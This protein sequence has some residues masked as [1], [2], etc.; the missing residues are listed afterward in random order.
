MVS[1]G[2]PALPPDVVARIGMVAREWAGHA[3]D[4]NNDVRLLLIYQQLATRSYDTAEI[5]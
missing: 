1:I 3:H 4:S 2:I 5:S